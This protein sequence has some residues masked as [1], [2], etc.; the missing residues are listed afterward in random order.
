MIMR[1]NRSS[2]SVRK[3]GLSREFAG[4]PT[5]LNALRFALH[6]CCH[7]STD[8]F[9]PPATPA[10]LFSRYIKG[11]NQDLSGAV[12]IVAGNLARAQTKTIASEEGRPG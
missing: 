9:A 6:Y 11:R 5:L 7:A 1:S 12:W 8:C 3:V 2:K 10:G 4:A